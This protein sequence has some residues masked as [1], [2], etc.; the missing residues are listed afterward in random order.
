MERGARAGREVLEHQVR[1]ATRGGALARVKQP[2]R[3]QLARER[4]CNRAV[5]CD[6]TLEH[7]LGVDAHARREILGHALDDDRGGRV[8]VANAACRG[9]AMVGEGDARHARQ[10]AVLYRIE[11][12]HGGALHATARAA[13]RFVERHRRGVRRREEDSLA[14]REGTAGQPFQRHG[15]HL[16][17]REEAVHRL[18]HAC[19]LCAV[20]E[21]APTREEESPSS[22]AHDFLAHQPRHQRQPRKQRPQRLARRVQRRT[23]HERATVPAVDRSHRM[24]EANHGTTKL[25][26][27]RTANLKNLAKTPQYLRYC[28]YSEEARCRMRCFHTKRQAV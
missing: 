9:G 11:R 21:R 17:D 7:G 4:W 12:L 15:K 1:G 14:A 25:C 20:H 5:E 24:G 2:R 23:H 13:Q 3:L 18:T 10:G 26:L 16:V 27:V 19:A 28:S 22:L 6:L 8:A